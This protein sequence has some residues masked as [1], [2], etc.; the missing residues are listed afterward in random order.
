MNRTILEMA[1]SMLWHARMHVSY[2]MD[3]VMT[4]VYLI[5]RMVPPPFKSQGITRYEAWTGVKPDLSHL[6]VFGCD[7]YRHIPKDERFNKFSA[8]ASR[9]VFIGYDE[10]KNGYYKIWDIFQRK[11]YRTRDVTFLETSFKNS[12]WSKGKLW[13]T[14]SHWDEEPTIESP[15]DYMRMPY[16]DTDTR[17]LIETIPEQQ[18]QQQPQQEQELEHKYE[19]QASEFKQ[20]DELVDMDPIQDNNEAE[21]ESLQAS[22]RYPQRD[23]QPRVFGD[24]MVRTDLNS[25]EQLGFVVTSQVPTSYEQAMVSPDKEKWLQ[26][27]SDELEA[28]NQNDTWSLTTLPP[29]RTAIDCKW[30]YAHKLDEHGNIIRHKARLVA[31]GFLQK[32]GIDFHETFAPVMK[33]KSL[34]I[35]L[36]L[37]VQGNY[38]LKQMD[39]ITAFL[40]AD[41]E[42]EVYMKQ[43][44]G[45]EQGKNLVCK[46]NKAIYGTKQAPHNW[47]GVLNEFII[48][49]GFTR[50]VSD[51]CVYVKITVTNHLIII[52]VFVDDITIAYELVDEQ[53]WLSIK[54]LFMNKFRMKDL[55]DCKLILG[56]RVT[57]DRTNGIL[58]IDNATHIK[59]LL[60]TYGMKQCKPQTTPE[61]QVQLIPTPEDQQGQVDIKLYQAMIGALNYLSQTCRPDIAHAVN[62]VSR[63]ASNPSPAHLI[64]AKRILR[65]LAGTIHVGLKYVKSETVGNNISVTA[66]TDA[67]WGGDHVD[68]RS[69]TG[70]V[71]RINNCT[72]S[73]ATKKQPTIAISSAEAE[74]MAVA[75]GVQELL[76]A[77]QFLS[78]LLPSDM[79]DSTRGCLLHCDSQSAIAISKNDVHHNRTKHIDIKH[80]FI[81]DHIKRNEIIMTWI[82]GEQQM[83]DLL[84]KPLDKIKFSTFK[85]QINKQQ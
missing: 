36:A 19:Q 6:R 24:A 55:G 15:D 48:S 4:A 31:K 82:P 70:Y 80:H 5:N 61:A 66:Y 79:F 75:A 65:Y 64:A 32:D 16:T 46:L 45:Y 27:Q 1:R 57:R 38:E 81:R 73:W 85:R 35:I 74:Y 29:H 69:T 21:P 49:V 18:Q 7:V 76:W 59:Q 2:W 17:T 37:T 44:K 72:V 63:Y 62:S 11:T 77:R 51:C 23:R 78:E 30:V 13:R 47:N 10:E 41:I 28:L 68:R 58:I 60:E 33:Y 39:V 40:N 26:A 50:L 8:R 52:G 83:A 12:T 53:E 14:Y 84:T 9:G 34:R 20:Q 56:M 42:E 71:I 43:P 67:D 25:S 54:S 22:S 3:A